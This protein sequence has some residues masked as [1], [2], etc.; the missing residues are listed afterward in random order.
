MVEKGD[1]Y[2]KRLEGKY[3]VGDDDEKWARTR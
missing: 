3:L 2:E 1:A